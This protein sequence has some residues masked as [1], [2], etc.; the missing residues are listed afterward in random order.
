M[1]L[2][3][4]DNIFRRAVSILSFRFYI[5]LYFEVLV[6]SYPVNN[7]NAVAQFDP[8]HFLNGFSN[9]D[10]FHIAVVYGRRVGVFGLGVP[11]VRFDPIQF[12]TGFSNND[13]FHIEYCNTRQA[14]VDTLPLER[15]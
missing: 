11:V 2:N 15:R 12:V 4:R 6:L 10:W 5:G 13:W 3:T 7:Y 14:I 8:I 1:G 9:N